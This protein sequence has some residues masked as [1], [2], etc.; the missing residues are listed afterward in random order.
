VPD[1]REDVS[2]AAAF[3]IGRLLG[4]SRTSMVASLMRWRQLGFQAARQTGTLGSSIFAGI[5]GLVVDRFLGG[6]FGALVGNAIVTA[7]EELLG[8]PSPLVSAGRPVLEGVGANE[9]LAAGLG[10][11]AK[12]FQ[13]APGEV[14]GRIG[15]ATPRLPEVG[16][17]DTSRAVLAQRL[18][19]EFARVAVQSLAADVVRA[20]PEIGLRGVPLDLLPGLAGLAVSGFGPVVAGP[21]AK[22]GD[23]L[24]RLVAERPE[25]TEDEEDL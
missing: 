16:V 14:L 17:L 19:T 13:G 11:S 15:E 1:G 23:A 20:G 18:D 8:N 4:L 5:E 21:H 2:L 22:G 25:R 3:E 6:A 12:A 24:D 7:P 9:V 10:V